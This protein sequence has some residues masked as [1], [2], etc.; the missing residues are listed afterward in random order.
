MSEGLEEDDADG[1]TEVET[2]GRALLRDGYT[3]VAERQHLRRDPAAFRAEYQ[4]IVGT[5]AE[6][7]ERDSPP[8]RNGRD[9]PARKGAEERRR[10]LDPLK[11][12]AEE[13]AGGDLLQPAGPTLAVVGPDEPVRVVT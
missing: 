7:G 3:L 13:G 10:G 11:A 5:K 1:D 12:D 9:T 8:V 4:D 6:G 2:L